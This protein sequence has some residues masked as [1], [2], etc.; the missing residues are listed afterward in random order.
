MEALRLEPVNGAVKD[1]LKKVAELIERE[2]QKKLK[3]P[4]VSVKTSLEPEVATKRHPLPSTPSTIPS[5][6]P[7]SF[8]GTPKSTNFKDAK[9]SRNSTKPSRVGGGIFRSSGNN[10]LFTPR[11]GSFDPSPMDIIEPEKS[12]KLT[13]GARSSPS[14]RDTMSGYSQ[15][16]PPQPS[17]TSQKRPTKAPT[18]LFD[19][20]REWSFTQSYDEKWNLICS[21]PPAKFPTMCKSSLE[22][23]MLVSI[24]EAFLG[25]LNERGNEGDII[26]TIKEYMERIAHVPRFP[27]LAMFLSPKEKEVASQI[28]NKVGIEYPPGPWTSV[29]GRGKP[30]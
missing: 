27:T 6:S 11:D 13:S 16:Q 19:F 4:A 26:Q 12:Q 2:K 30:Y 20:I 15:T 23:T 3:G 29:V 8:Q 24:L 25:I 10:T 5:I 1:E 17:A 9:Q 14:F 21:I 7:E 28:F 22:P 18:T